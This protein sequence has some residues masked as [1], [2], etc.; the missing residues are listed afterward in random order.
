MW[1]EVKSLGSRRRTNSLI[2]KHAMKGNGT[3]GKTFQKGKNPKNVITLLGPTP[4]SLVFC[5]MIVYSKIFPNYP[6]DIPFV[7]LTKSLKSSFDS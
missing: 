2:R 3:K 7:S 4:A 6:K 1:D 5:L